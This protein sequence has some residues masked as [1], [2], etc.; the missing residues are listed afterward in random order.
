M[1]DITI[2]IIIIIIIKTYLSRINTSVIKN[3]YQHGSCEK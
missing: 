3:C 1:G 2:I